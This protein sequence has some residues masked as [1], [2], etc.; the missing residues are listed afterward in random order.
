MKVVAIVQ[1]RMGSTRFP[2]KVLESVCGK[3]LLRH[4]V[5]R[6]K[7]ANKIHKMVIATTS[8]DLDN[9]LV[10]EAV[11][12]EGVDIFRGSEEDVL[13]R[14]YRAARETKAELVVRITSD[15]PLIDPVILDSMIGLFLRK[16]TD[17]SPVD[18]LSNTLI[19]TF[20]RGLDAEVFPFE[21]LEKAFNQAKEAFQREHVTPYIW[22]NPDM[23]RLE[24]FKNGEDLSFY[25][26]TVDE[27]EDLH[28]IREI[29]KELYHEGRCFLLNEVLE[30]FK[31]RPQLLKINAAIKQKSLKHEQG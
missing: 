12:I 10:D 30:L 25:R 21:V 22:Q 6:T 31:Q 9:V 3:T 29:Y 15:C 28:L 2:G 16:I 14:Y 27:K 19:R 7:K 23:F 18:Y 20:P 13:D 4:V 5:E 1:A 11:K 8:T 24:C 26:W 17:N